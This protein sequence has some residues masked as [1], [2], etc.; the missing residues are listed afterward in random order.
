MIFR[1]GSFTE[2]NAN[3][4]YDILMQDD[5]TVLAFYKTSNNLKL[6]NESPR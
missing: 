2:S 5:S 6:D 4:K 3:I 1:T